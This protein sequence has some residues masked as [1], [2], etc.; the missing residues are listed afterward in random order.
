MLGLTKLVKLDNICKEF[1]LENNVYAKVEN[2]NPSGSVKDRPCYYML[3]K[4]K[5]EGILKDGGTVIEATSGN[6]GISL[7]YFQK[8][9]NYKAII[10]MPSS[11]SRERRE[12]ISS[13]GA[14][15]ELVDGGMSVANKR[16]ME[17][18]EEIKD[19]I[20]F[21]QFDNPN[22]VLA[23]YHST[24]KEINNDLED[25]DYLF[26][27]IGTGGTISGIGKFYKELKKKTLIIGVEPYESPLI[28]KG[29]ASSHL[30]QGIG[31]NFIPNILDLNVIDEMTT[32]KGLDAI[33]MA[34]LVRA[35]EGIDCGYSSGAALA[36]CINYLKEKNIKG[37]NVVVIFP[38]KGDRYQW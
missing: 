25:L 9:L 32:C 13:L 29:C 33:A 35:L 12:M 22:N 38:D 23:H 2:T 8:E 14:R 19:S 27:G 16:A 28:T 6:M 15:L 11:M 3:T 31:A 34:K 36:A 26:A 7:A 18:K 21:K 4:Y 1:N 30:I 37:K 17:L 24:A 5:E 10:V 20:L